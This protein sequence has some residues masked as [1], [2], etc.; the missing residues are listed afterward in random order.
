[1][2]AGQVAQSLFYVY[3]RSDAGQLQIV[4]KNGAVQLQHFPTRS[5]CSCGSFSRLGHPCRHWIIAATVENWPRQAADLAALTKQR[6][7]RSELRV[8]LPM[9]RVIV[10]PEK[11]LPTVSNRQDERFAQL[12]ASFMPLVMK[13]SPSQQASSLLRSIIDVLATKHADI[14]FLTAVW[15]V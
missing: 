11:S 14:S 13:I 1:M 4:R 5:S 12:T 3:S 6:W 2:V 7:H 9:G 8:S 10:I 15:A